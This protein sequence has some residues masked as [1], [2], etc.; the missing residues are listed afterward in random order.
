M[1]PSDG[2]QKVDETIDDLGQQCLVLRD[3][4]DLALAQQVAEDFDD[5]LNGQYAEQVVD[6]SLVYEWCVLVDRPEEADSVAS[7]LVL[8]EN[9][10]CFVRQRNF[11]NQVEYVPFKR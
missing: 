7:E 5:V 3:H 2:V 8:H 10:S 4:D 1:L 6:I 9:L 11:F